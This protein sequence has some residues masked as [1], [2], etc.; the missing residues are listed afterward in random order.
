MRYFTVSSRGRKGSTT[1][2]ALGYEYEVMM[3]FNGSLV[4][5][6]IYADNRKSAIEKCKV[7]AMSDNYKKEIQYQNALQQINVAYK[8]LEAG[9]HT[10][11]QINDYVKRIKNQYNIIDDTNESKVVE[12]IVT[13]NETSINTNAEES[14]SIQSETTYTAY[15]RTFSTYEEAV[16]YCNESDFDPSHIET[17]GTAVSDTELFHLYNQ[18]FS[19]YWDA[20]NYAITNRSDVSMI[21]S[22]RA[23]IS[24]QRLR[25]LRT[26]YATAKY[27]MSYEDAKEYYNHL[28]TIPSTS[29]SEDI[30]HG[31]KHVIERH[32]SRMNAESQRQANM[33]QLINQQQDLLNK[34]YSLGMTKK[35]SGS[36]VKYYYNDECIYT[37]FSGTSVEK[38]YNDLFQVYQQKFKQVG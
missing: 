32:E 4:D 10:A 20:Y 6:L 5:F 38:I 24:N 8:L 3:D 15:N 9:E 37:W 31:L 25:D 36:M 1:F 26:M 2:K 27:T 17:V 11:D 19:S 23:N 22:S 30:I 35:E 18:T 21:L 29:N 33:L 7:I 13:T 34:M 14:Q 28:T 16:N 12:S